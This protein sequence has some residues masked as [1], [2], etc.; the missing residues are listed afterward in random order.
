MSEIP[1]KES[2]KEPPQKKKRKPPRIEINTRFCKGCNICVAFC[3]A[4]VL[5][6]KGAKAAVV[7][8][9]ACTTCMMCELRCP[10]F[11]IA[12]FPEE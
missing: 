12:V 2:A 8:L 5:A 1:A 9:E 7:N 4:K 3:P 11:A 6:I 10:D